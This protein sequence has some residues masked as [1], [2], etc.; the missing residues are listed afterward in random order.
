MMNID[1]IPGDS[2]NLK[3]IITSEDVLS[4]AKQSGDYNPLH[5]DEEFA[6]KTIFQTRIVHGN[7]IVAMFTSMIS[8]EIPGPGAFLIQQEVKFLSPIFVNSEVNLSLSVEKYLGRAR[9]LFLSGLCFS[10][11]VKCI[12]CKFKVSSNR[13]MKAND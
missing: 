9:I 7:L 1:F 2:V 10:G 3:K 5:L 12:E 4:F 11:G 13:L 6:Q 8:H